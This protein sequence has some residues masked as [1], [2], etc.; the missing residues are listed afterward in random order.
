[1]P[2]KG[3]LQLLPETRKRT[4]IK[5]PGENRMLYIGSVFVAI[6]LVTYGAFSFQTTNL[7]KKIAASDEQLMELEGQR[8]KQEEKALLTISKQLNTTAQIVKSHVFWS[9]GLEKMEAAVLPNVQF[10]SFSALIGDDSIRMRVVADN[11]VTV[12]KQLA[13]FVSDD[14]IKDVSL[15]GVNVLTTGKLDFSAKIVFDKSKFL[16]SQ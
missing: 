2:E 11:Y 12:A 6:V 7:E 5:I 15:E 13:A 3:G 1:M 9:T 14:S 8:N 16:K 10:R 4:E